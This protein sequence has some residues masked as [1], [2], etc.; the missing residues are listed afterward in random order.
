MKNDSPLLVALLVALNFLLVPLLV[1]AGAS[2]TLQQ[3]V[4]GQS[5]KQDLSPALRDIPP[6]TTTALAP[7]GTTR[8]IPLQRIPRPVG[9]KVPTRDPALQFLP[10]APAMPAFVQNFA[11]IKNA[12]NPFTVLPPDTNGDVGPSHYVQM[13]NIS[14]AI[15]DKSGNLLYGPAANNTLWTGFGGPCET[16]NDGDPIVLYDHLADRWLMSQFAV[17]GPFY[18]C[19]AISQTGDPTGAW[20]RYAFLVH[21]TKMNDYPKFGVWPDGYYMSVNQFNPGWAGGG[22]SCFIAPTCWRA[23]R[24]RSSTSTWG[25]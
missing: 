16:Y 9:P 12:D 14:F 19:I 3:P 17:P 1:E 5:L 22:S 13:V 25:R 23:T 20:Y 21:A 4:V 11:G 15:W 7:A 6:V 10:V 8:E 2:A 24:P 18:Q